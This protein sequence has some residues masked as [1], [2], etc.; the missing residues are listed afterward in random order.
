ML[1]CSSRTSNIP[2]VLAACKQD[3]QSCG[4]C[5]VLRHRCRQAM[6]EHTTAGCWGDHFELCDRQGLS[7]AA[8]RHR[9]TSLSQ[10]LPT[11]PGMHSAAWCMEQHLRQSFSGPS[12]LNPDAAATVWHLKNIRNQLATVLAQVPARNTEVAH[13]T[14]QAPHPRTTTQPALTADP[15]R[16]PEAVHAVPSVHQLLCVCLRLCLKRGWGHTT[17]CRL[18][19]ES[20]SH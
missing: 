11:E 1:C 6:C 15:S 17:P 12:R 14:Q 7:G 20:F 10:G 3:Q 9:Q 13:A 5:T 19:A 18:S 8:H 16:T 2:Q 4:T